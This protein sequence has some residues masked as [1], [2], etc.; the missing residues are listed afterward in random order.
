M[1]RGEVARADW[2]PMSGRAAPATRNWMKSREAHCSAVL[3]IAGKG[4]DS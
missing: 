4:L 3:Q 1:N 2:A